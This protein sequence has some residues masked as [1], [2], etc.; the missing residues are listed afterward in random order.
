[1]CALNPVSLIHAK[2]SLLPNSF[3]GVFLYS[4]RPLYDPDCWY[5]VQYD[6]NSNRVTAMSKL[7]RKFRCDSIRISKVDEYVIVNLQTCL[8]K[9]VF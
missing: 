1:M 2:H 3:L 6:N 5:Y 7:E 4:L 8:L 9:M